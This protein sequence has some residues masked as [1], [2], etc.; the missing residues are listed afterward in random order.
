MADA[1]TSERMSPRLLK[2]A[3]RAKRN[4]DA[5]FHSL[6]HLVDVDALRCAFARLRPKA[7]VG[8][9][10]VTKEMYG[11]AL[12]ENLQNLHE[13]MR[14]QRYR[15]QP[16]RRVHIPKGDGRTRPLGISALEDKI[17]QSALRDLLEAVYEQDFLDCS[18]GFRPG[19]GAH[20]A[21]RAFH[22]VADKGGANWVIEADIA[23]FFDQIPRKK[24]LDLIAC[25]IPDGSI[26]RLIGKCLHVGVLDG[27]ELTTPDDGTAQGSVL[28]PLMANVY[29]HYVLDVWFEHEV[30]PRMHGKAT[31]IRYADD[32]V[33]CF[34]RE[35]DALRVMDVL[36]KRMA[37]YGLAL[38][39]DKTRLVS[40]ERPCWSQRN[41]KGPDSFDFLGFTL[42]WRRSRRGR[43]VV[44]C[45]TRRAR[46]TRAI[47]AAYDWCRHN[48]HARIAEQHV[49][50]CRKL[51][52]HYQYFGV[53]GNTRS[54][55][56]LC[57]HTC[58]A[59]QKW[60]NRR[61]QRGNLPWK[62]FVDLLRDFPLPLPRV[63]V[64]IWGT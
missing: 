32:F 49:G 46:I 27:E 25:R 60:L 31:L 3:A 55:S 28:S 11:Q 42:Y 44:G 22:R 16:I 51:R 53:N 21:I 24:L 47:K 59:W 1:W 7:A 13:R 35:D 30:K 58:R 26:R 6:A 4:P 34:E 2:V 62:R 63:Y 56:R 48:R 61:S 33:L 8:V 19:R 43:W 5:Q 18:H 14:T 36:P 50:L 29:L 15:H 10:G 41:G 45:K 52:G 57:H 23:S 12:E 40:F 9:D 54:L 38:Q 20:D 39:P 64:Q 17:V 37:K